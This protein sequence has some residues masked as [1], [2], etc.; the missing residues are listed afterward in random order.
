MAVGW[1]DF[2]SIGTYFYLLGST[3]FYFDII[4]KNKISLVKGVLI[5]AILAILIIIM[6][7]R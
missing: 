4:K 1:L 2:N 3:A 5:Y 7:Y 6:T